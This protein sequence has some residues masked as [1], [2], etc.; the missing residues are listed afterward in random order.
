MLGKIFIDIFKIESQGDWYFKKAGELRSA[1]RILK[2][3]GVYS[4]SADALGEYEIAKEKHD[5]QF[6]EFFIKQMA[7]AYKSVGLN[8]KDLCCI[9]CLQKP[10]LCKCTGKNKCLTTSK[11]ITFGG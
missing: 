11:K 1:T 7:A 6:K 9:H 8:F 3:K 4:A 5:I 2:N 10:D